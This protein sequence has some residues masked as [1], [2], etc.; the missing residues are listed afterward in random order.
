MSRLYLDIIRHR[1]GLGFQFFIK[2][3]LGKLNAKF[4]FSSGHGIQ[5][6]LIYCLLLGC[7]QNILGLLL[8]C[9]M[10]NVEQVTDNLHSP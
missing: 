6:D 9:H 3:V 10:L 5:E 8:T 7:L 2:R 1:P 4:C